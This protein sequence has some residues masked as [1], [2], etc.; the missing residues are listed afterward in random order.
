MLMWSALAI[1]ALVIPVATARSTSSSRLVDASVGLMGAACD[2]GAGQH[3]GCFDAI[4]I[5]H[6]DIEQAH[7]GSKLA[8]QGDDLT[9]VGCLADN[10]DVSLTVEN[11]GEAGTNDALVIGDEYPYGHVTASWRGRVTSTLQPRSAFG[12]AAK[13][14]PS[15]VTRSAIPI[16]PK[17]PVLGEVVIRPSSSIVIW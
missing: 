3:S 6:A 12:P 5:R 16:S 11:G 13:R 14:P 10:L 2:V 7:V 8:S 9:P 15:S 1:S 4:H 17:P